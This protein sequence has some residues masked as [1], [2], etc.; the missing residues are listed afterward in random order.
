MVADDWLIGLQVTV[1][2]KSHGARRF[3][4][5][6]NDDGYWS[7]LDNFS[8]SARTIPAGEKAAFKIEL[9][10]LVD[11]EGRNLLSLSGGVRIAARAG[12]ARRTAEKK[13]AYG[14]ASR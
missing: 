7:S 12:A 14:E 6:D 5:A 1:S 11:T 13:T 3:F 8:G 10:R 2:D 9:R 4:R